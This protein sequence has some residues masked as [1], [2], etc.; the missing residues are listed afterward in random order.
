M[1]L[2]L[3]FLFSLTLLT[4]CTT[5]TKSSSPY[6]LSDDSANVPWTK[7][8]DDTSR[9]NYIQKMLKK[10]SVTSTDIWV[11]VYPY[12]KSL[13]TNQIKAILDEQAY[14]ENWTD[15]KKNQILNAK[16]KTAY[17]SLIN[18]GQC[19]ALDIVSSSADSS[20][21][22]YWY[23]NI[24]QQNYGSEVAFKESIDTIVLARSK[25]YNLNKNMEPKVNI[26]LDKYYTF[27]DVCTARKIDITKSFKIVFK[28]RFDKNL[29]PTELGWIQSNATF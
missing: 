29:V 7:V 19:F 1:R 3:L 9:T 25:Q 16:L 13:I 21:L 24:V 28:P 10:N 27:A 18:K 6:Y 4:S 20:E 11:K 5:P 22:K 8:V 23:G 17:D 15:A 12:T 14:K 2:F 26:G